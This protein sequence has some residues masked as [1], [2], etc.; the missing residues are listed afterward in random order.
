MRTFIARAMADHEHSRR[1]NRQADSA[2]AHRQFPTF[3]IGRRRLA[4]STASPESRCRNRSARLVFESKRLIAHVARQPGIDKQA[5]H[6]WI[7]QAADDSGRQRDLLTRE[8]RQEL[9][10]PRRLVGSQNSRPSTASRRRPERSPV[11]DSL[12]VLMTDAGHSYW[13][14]ILV[15]RTKTPLCCLGTFSL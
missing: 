8:E 6:R 14:P 12:P 11:L 5:R 10:R 1:S 3:R 13:C 9:K 15:I 4:V 7:R 2:K